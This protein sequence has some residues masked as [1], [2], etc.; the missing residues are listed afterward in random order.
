MGSLAPLK[1]EIRVRVAFVRGNNDVEVRSNLIQM[2]LPPRCYFGSVEGDYVTTNNVI[3]EHEFQA[4]NIVRA[5]GGSCAD[6]DWGVG[7]QSLA[8]LSHEYIAV[9]EPYTAVFD[10]FR[11]LGVIP[12]QAVEF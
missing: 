7:I 12:G 5:G 6:R 8:V 9:R 4:E 2:L 11:L 10:E 3:A 1:Q